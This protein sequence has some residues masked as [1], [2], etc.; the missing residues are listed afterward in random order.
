MY[1]RLEIS[2]LKQAHTQPPPPPAPLLPPLQYIYMIQLREFINQ[3]VYKVGKTT[4]SHLARYP[5]GS[6]L[7][8][9]VPSSDC[10][11]D[12][13]TILQLFRS[14]YI[15]KMDIGNEYFEGDRESMFDEICRVVRK[16]E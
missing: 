10:D 14:K 16:I 2:T 15:S 7:L 1:T 5:K 12:E 9:H 6:E 8:L 11:T 3:P 13:R 4:Q